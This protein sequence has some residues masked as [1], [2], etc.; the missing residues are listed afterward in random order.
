MTYA[1]TTLLGLNQPTTGSESGVW[2]DDINNG[3]TQLLEV[4]LV[5][6]NTI[7]YDGNVTLSVSNGNSSSSFGS[8]TT[9]SGSTGVAQYPVL[10]LTGARTAVRTITAPSSS[11][12]YRVIN[13]TTGGFST[14]VNAS[15]TT[16]V[17]IPPGSS[18]TL[19][20][21][22]SDYQGVSSVIGN[23]TFTD[24]N[25]Y[26]SYQGSV[27]SYIQL[28]TQNSN[29]GTTASTDIIVTNNNGTA[30]TYYGDFGMNSSGFTGSGAFNQPNMV[31]LTST[32]GDLALGTTTAN[33][34]H[35]VVNS[36]T[37][38]AMAISSS[39]TVTINGSSITLGGNFTTS[40]AYT[41]T[42]TTTGNTSV[43]LP[44]SGTLLT[45]TGSG[46]SLTFG[47]GSLS[48]AGNVTH[49]GAFTQTITATGNTS[50]TLP[51]SGTLIS[52]STALS[53]AVTGTPSSSTYLR[54]DG[55]WASI[56]GG[57]GTVTSVGMTVPS[58]LSVS[59]SPVTTSG[60]LAVSLSGTALP[61]ANGGTGLTSPGTSGNVLTSNGSS[62]TSSAP[63]VNWKYLGSL[64]Q[65]SAFSIPS[66]YTFYYIQYTSTATANTY[67]YIQFNGASSSYNYIGFS[68]YSQASFSNS[69]YS[70]IVL[71][72]S[73]FQIPWNGEIWF[74]V[75]NG[76]LNGNGLTGGS[77]SECA[78]I[79][80]SNYGITSLSSVT[81]TINPSSNFSARLY[82]MT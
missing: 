24:S 44:T 67:P 11:R 19:I 64:T 29:S 37:T 2:G 17:S 4:S 38:D 36:G 45:T 26:A 77:Y 16:G 72:P 73:S 80:F 39:G 32:T 31:Y 63:S 59:G 20:W 75:A 54:G 12:V 33:G 49:S 48:L 10:L 60:T 42:L 6:L 82:G 68:S 1:N 66:G 51:T 25:I 41:T 61:A 18:A 55:T 22:G 76:Y 7:T 5:G 57:S 43:T 53:G 79:N 40:G 34:I 74:S 81:L 58:F 47:T 69:S 46:S 35:F 23:L 27:N 52:S 13:Q 15:A 65:G 71:S 28:I 3:T 21:N 70:I 62:W 78:M 9:T 30:T 56:S 14:T 50:V 8:T